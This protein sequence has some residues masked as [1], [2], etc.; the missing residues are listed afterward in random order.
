[1]QSA[2]GISGVKSGELHADVLLSDV[3]KIIFEKSEC[4]IS[5]PMYFIDGCGRHIKL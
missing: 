5:L 4:A 3:T 2:D 1:M